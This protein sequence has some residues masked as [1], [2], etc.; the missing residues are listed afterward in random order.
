M[1]VRF[2]LPVAH[3]TYLVTTNK[4]KPNCDGELVQGYCNYGARRI[5]LYRNPNAEA[6]RAALWHEYVHALLHELGRPDMADDEALV[7]GIA[8]AV[9]RVRL[10]HPEI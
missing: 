1:K 4:R 2:R 3:T 8:Q 7:E 5:S 6:M 10:E 9:M